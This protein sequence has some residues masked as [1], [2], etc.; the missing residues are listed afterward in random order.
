MSLINNHASKA[1]PT[2]R[3]RPAVGADVFYDDLGL[4][5]NTLDMFSSRTELE[6]RLETEHQTAG[7]EQQARI[8]T[9][10]AEDERASLTNCCENDTTSRSSIVFG[11]L[12]T[13]RS[14]S[15]STCEFFSCSSASSDDEQNAQAS[16]LS[17][18]LKR[19]QHSTAALPGDLSFVSVEMLQSMDSDTDQSGKT[20]RS[21]RSFSESGSMVNHSSTFMSSSP[22][23]RHSGRLESAATD[24]SDPAAISFLLTN[25]FADFHL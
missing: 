2:T 12:R 8:A 15:S 6:Q 21:Q 25:S 18:L 16:L 4:D 24:Q 23:R 17:A 22:A 5:D 9:A 19:K 7:R 11:S 20:Q 14:T 1:P 3:R 13:P 10:D